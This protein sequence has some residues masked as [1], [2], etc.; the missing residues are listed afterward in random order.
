MRGVVAARA[1]DGAGKDHGVVFSGVFV[2]EL[3]AALFVEE[4]SDKV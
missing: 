4:V 2:V 1:V 3:V